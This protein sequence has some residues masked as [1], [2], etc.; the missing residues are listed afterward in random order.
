ME[1][2]TENKLLIVA[3]SVIII[4]SGVSVFLN[5][6][7]VWDFLEHDSLIT[8]FGNN[9][10]GM[11]KVYGDQDICQ[12]IKIE[13]SS[14]YPSM[15]SSNTIIAENITFFGIPKIVVG[16]VIVFYR[17]SHLVCHRVVQINTDSFSVKGDNNAISDPNPVP[18]IEVKFVVV[19][20][21]R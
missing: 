19:A 1:Q 15:T 14:M 12:L 4:L 3:L 17:D 16:D 10:T 5:V 18:F 8:Y 21:L 11:I 7:Q 9:D 2:K 13:G 6:R 20:V